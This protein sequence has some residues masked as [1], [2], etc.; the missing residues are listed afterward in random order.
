LGQQ[1]RIN[2]Q[3]AQIPQIQLIPY[4][5]CEICEICGCSFVFHILDE[6]TLEEK[7]EGAGYLNPKT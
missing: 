3:I 4:S 6:A 5:L 1:K 7:R 2:P